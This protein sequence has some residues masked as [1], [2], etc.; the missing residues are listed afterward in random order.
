MKFK[1]GD[2]VKLNPNCDW[3][4]ISINTIYKDCL[5]ADIVEINSVFDS[6]FQYFGKKFVYDKCYEIIIFS[7]PESFI[8]RKIT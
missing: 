4:D 7:I 6:S 3:G 1:K 2:M 5:L 8:L